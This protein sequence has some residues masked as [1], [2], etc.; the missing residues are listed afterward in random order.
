VAVV[1][2]WVEAGL[3]GLVGGVALVLGA[4]VAWWVRVSR[5]VV[6]AIMAFG[7]G[8]LISALA[9]DLVDEAQRAGGS[10]RPPAASSAA[11][12]CTS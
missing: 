9:F 11:P 7:A 2:Q 4:A 12:P 5:R 1:P 8:V 6:A 10:G 3:W